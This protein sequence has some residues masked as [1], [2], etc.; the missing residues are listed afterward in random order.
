[1]R[2]ILSYINLF[3]ST[4]F[5]C[6]IAYLAMPFFGRKEELVH[7]MAR[8]WARVYLIIGGVNVTFRGGDHLKEPPYIIMSNHQSA[9]DIMSLL[10]GLPV[11]FKFVAKQELFRIPVFGWALKRAGYVSLDRENPRKALKDMEVAAQKIK[12][13]A[14]LVIFPEG[15]RSANGRLLPFK[16]GAF[17]LAMKAGVPIIPLGI[18]GTAL[19]QPEGY[20]VPI[21]KG[22]V[23][24]VAGEPIPVEGKGTGYKDALAEQVRSEIERLMARSSER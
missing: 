7:R 5:L 22:S 13:G 14:S 20:N 3:C 12:D 6:F 24:I 1:M 23:T 18:K 2:R 9:L 21:R 17:S 11:S 4:L 15:T 8:F 10:I 16:K 19:L